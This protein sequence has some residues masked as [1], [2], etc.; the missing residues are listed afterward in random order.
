MNNK[1]VLVLIITAS[2]F[3]V[4]FNFI[5]FSDESSCS[6]PEYDTS[7]L[8][9]NFYSFDAYNLLTNEG[10]NV[11]ENLS[12]A[13]EESITPDASGI[14]F[15]EGATAG[16]AVFLDGLR[17]VGAFLFLLTPLPIIDLFNSFGMPLWATLLIAAPLSTWY[18]L[19][20]FEFIR[21]DRF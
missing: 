6:I 14:G 11:N 4:M 20:I 18:L 7:F 12:D 8:M 9:N 21:G 2:I 1:D 13:V 5:C 3:S 19:G 17:M 10:I 15:L 16:A